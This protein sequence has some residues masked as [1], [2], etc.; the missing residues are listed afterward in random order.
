MR[1]KM[2]LTEGGYDN[3]PGV[4]VLKK[5][6]DS[7]KKVKAVHI[8]SGLLRDNCYIRLTKSQCRRVG[9]FL[10]EAGGE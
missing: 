1:N 6:K 2:K 3:N 8:K 9:E 7:E 5:E 10:L 4:V